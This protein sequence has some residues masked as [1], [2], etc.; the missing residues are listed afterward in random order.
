MRRA[1]WISL[2]IFITLFLTHLTHSADASSSRPPDEP[3]GTSGPVFLRPSPNFDSPSFSARWSGAQSEKDKIRYLLDRIGNSKQRFI[4]NGSVYDG[5]KARQWFL[6]KIA[7]FS[8][9]PKTAEDFIRNVSSK[10]MKTG[11][12]YRV[13]FPDGKTYPL[14]EVLQNE[15]TAFEKFLASPPDLARL[16]LPLQPAPGA[17]PGPVSVALVQAAASA[18]STPKTSD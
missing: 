12:P 3:Q 8:G 15:L 1:E 11:E 10:S 5:A 17:Q 2:T 7:R 13:Q 14:G 4:R 6:F 18:T 16:S 9:Q